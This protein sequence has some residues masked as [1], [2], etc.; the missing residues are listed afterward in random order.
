MS[1]NSRLCEQNCLDIKQNKMSQ[2]YMRLIII[3]CSVNEKCGFLA[4]LIWNIY[5]Y[6]IKVNISHYNNSNERC[7][8]VGEDIFFT[9]RKPCG[10]KLIIPS[11]LF[12]SKSLPSIFR[13][14][15]VYRPLN[16]LAPSRGEFPFDFMLKIDLYKSDFLYKNSASMIIYFLI[17]SLFL[18]SSSRWWRWWVYM[19]SLKT[20]MMMIICH[21]IYVR[22]WKKC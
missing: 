1:H 19:C 22:L 7:T 5:R 3:L 12:T 15:S 16:P 10:L 8:T 6:N 14:R 11:I 20:F 18:V 17:I 9:S 21:N 4:A 13:P 2:F